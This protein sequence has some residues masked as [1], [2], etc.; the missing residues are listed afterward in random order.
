MTLN[1]TKHEMRE[2]NKLCQRIKRKR[3]GDRL[4]RNVGNTGSRAYF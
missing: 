2:N 4:K 3:F 1:E